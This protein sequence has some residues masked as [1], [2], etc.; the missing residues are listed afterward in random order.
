MS[1]PDVFMIGVIVGVLLCMAMLIL[2]RV[3][4]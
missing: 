1:K 2:S 3:I 4:Q